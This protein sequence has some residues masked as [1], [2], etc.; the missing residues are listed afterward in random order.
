MFH[1]KNPATYFFI[2]CII[3]IFIFSA[4]LEVDMKAFKLYVCP[5]IPAYQVIP[6]KNMDCIPVRGLQVSVPLRYAEKNPVKY[7]GKFFCFFVASN[8][9]NARQNSASWFRTQIPRRIKYFY[10]DKE[11]MSVPDNH[12]N[13]DPRIPSGWLAHSKNNSVRWQSL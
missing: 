10:F 6:G 1:L 11:L 7:K 13:G 8:H 3:L 9:L 4:T 5:K 12:S 2:A